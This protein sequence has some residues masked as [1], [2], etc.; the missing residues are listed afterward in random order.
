MTVVQ[1]VLLV[2]VGVAGGCVALA[3]DPLRQ[4]IL[5]GLLGLLLALLFFALQ[6]PDVALSQVVVG[7]VALPT[8]ILLALAEVRSHEESDDE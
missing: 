5:A 4:A 1:A 3:R 8:M 6:A 7:G 2:L